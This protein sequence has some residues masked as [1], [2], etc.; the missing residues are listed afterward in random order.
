M[1]PGAAADDPN[2]AQL[3][4]VAAVLGELRASLVFV[5]GCATGLL[6]TA[7]RAQ[8]IRVTTDVDLVAEVATAHAYYRVEAALQARGLTHDLSPGA[9]ICR[10]VCKGV[11]VDLM[12]SEP[13]VLGFHNRWYPL[14]VETARE[15]ALPSGQPIRLIHAPLFIATKLEAFKGR[16]NADYMM[17]HDLEDIMTVV[18]GRVELIEETRSMPKDLL[19]YLSDEFTQ[20]INNPAFM[21]ALPGHLPGD[22]ASQQRLPELLNRLRALSSLAR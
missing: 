8:R 12:P 16:G 1:T 5:G 17:S 7:A 21:E 20:L 19:R 11:T 18:D 3:G 6:V 15:I 14:A 10:W 9:P 2:L 22:I 13:G 4:V